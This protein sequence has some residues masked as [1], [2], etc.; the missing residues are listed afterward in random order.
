MVGEWVSEWVSE[1]GDHCSG[2]WCVGDEWM[3]S[4]FSSRWVCSVWVS[5]YVGSERGEGGVC[6]E[7]VVNPWSLSFCVVIEWWV[8]ECVVSAWVHSECMSACQCVT[9]W[10]INGGY[11]GTW[12]MCGQRA[13]VWWVCGECLSVWWVCEFTLNT[14]GQWSISVCVTYFYWEIFPMVMGK[15]VCNWPE[16]KTLA[17]NK[18]DTPIEFSIHSFF[19][20]TELI[21]PHG[22][23]KVLLGVN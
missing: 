20:T 21:S 2:E 7:W 6:G 3:V 15:W 4:V 17:V 5:A 9:V 13:S 19:L 8:C 14:H 12:L 22:K 16:S 11:A 23:K 1:C 18:L 10:W